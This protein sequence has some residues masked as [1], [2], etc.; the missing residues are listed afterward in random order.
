MVQRILQSAEWGNERAMNEDATQDWISRWS[1]PAG[2]ALL[3]RQECRT[4][5]IA[6][7]R[8][9][10]S[11]GFDALRAALDRGAGPAWLIGRGAASERLWPSWLRGRDD[12]VLTEVTAL[13]RRSRLESSAELT[14]AIREWI[15]EWLQGLLPGPA[16]R[17]VYSGACARMFQD[18]IDDYP[19]VAGCADALAGR[20]VIAV[21][22]WAGWES[23]G[24]L[25]SARGGSLLTSVPP[26]AEPS[27]ARRAGA[28]AASVVFSAGAIARHVRDWVSSASAR[29]AVNES[30]ARS[31]E[32]PELWIGLLPT[33]YRMNRIAIESVLQPA[34]RRGVR[35]G[36]LMIGELDEGVRDE[37]VLTTIKPGEFGQGF[38]GVRDEILARPLEQAVV[39]DSFAELVGDVG[40]AAVR[41]ARA[42]ARFARL[43]S[44]LSLHGMQ[45]AYDP[46]QMA[47]FVSIDVARA[48]FA[49]R[50]AAVLAKRLGD[51]RTPVVLATTGFVSIGT[52]CAELQERGF[53]VVEVV[54]GS[55][56]EGWA[57]T[58]ESAAGIVF[59][60]TRAEVRALEP[61]NLRVEVGAL[62]KYDLAPARAAGVRRRNVLLVSNYQ[63]RDWVNR[64]GNFQQVTL[65]EALHTFDLLAREHALELNFRWR[66][67][68]ADVPSLVAATH[69]K[70]PWVELSH[71]ARPLGE[72][73]RWAD[74]V[75]S[76]PS[77]SV[78]E[79]LFAGIPVFMHAEPDCWRTAVANWMDPERV[80]YHA[81]DGARQVKRVLLDMARASEGVL[82]PEQR[83]RE[84]LFGGDGVADT[85]STLQRIARE[86]SKES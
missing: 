64:F 52:I 6:A 48:T 74:V 54:H 13:R 39:P 63:H 11:L 82:R 22:D 33:W 38:G 78:A 32:Q 19:L 44:R 55:V 41:C 31:T 30:R 70:W 62:P 9:P 28:V 17:R 7:P 35:F 67:H 65:D 53:P 18:T 46:M 24:E 49:E 83:A 43:P 42:S 5:I 75:I 69:A 8:A 12:V 29:S 47:R 25:L 34:I 16:S 1:R 20:D 4:V 77:S 21:G 73:L 79:A 26:R 76:T 37:H 72:D 57:G 51:P 3:S 59:V 27:A 10:L 58:Y 84:L 71:N 15:D 40:H 23:L 81:E 56:G 68:P 66:P 2:R 36:T 45:L 61:T 60:P 80:F 50:R 86:F 85:L 14:A